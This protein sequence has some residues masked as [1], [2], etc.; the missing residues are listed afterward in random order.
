M[1]TAARTAV[2]ATVSE[3]CHDAIFPSVFLLSLTNLAGRLRLRLRL[4]L[5]IS[6]DGDPTQLVHTLHLGSFQLYVS[7]C[8]SQRIFP[9]RTPSQ[10]S[11]EVV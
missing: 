4:R 11:F 9:Y 10:G 7:L 6:L 5:R 8:A 3:M 2:A 1:L